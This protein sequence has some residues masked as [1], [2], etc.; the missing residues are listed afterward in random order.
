MQRSGPV[1][2]DSG[3]ADSGRVRAPLAFRSMATGN[4][5]KGCEGPNMQCVLERLRNKR[6]PKRARR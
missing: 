1:I 2:R 6:G 3:S 4:Y 5:E